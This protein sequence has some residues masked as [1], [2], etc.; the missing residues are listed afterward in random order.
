MIY[1]LNK[2]S[3]YLIIKG[4]INVRIHRLPILPGGEK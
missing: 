1:I 3:E 2:Y 4:A